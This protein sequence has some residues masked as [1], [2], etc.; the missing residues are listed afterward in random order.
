MASFADRY[1]AVME[2]ARRGVVAANAAVFQLREPLAVIL[3]LTYGVIRAT[4]PL[5]R[6]CLH[7]LTGTDQFSELLRLY[8]RRAADDEAGHEG[9]LLNDVRRLGFVEEQLIGSFPLAAISAM[10]GSQY[11]LIEHYHPAV[12]LGYIGLLEGF[13]P[14]MAEVEGLAA[15][16][17][18][19]PSMLATLK[20][21]AEVDPHHRQE[22]ERVL[23]AVP[24]NS[25][26]R[27]IIANGLR[28]AEYACQAVE[29]AMEGHEKP[30]VNGVGLH[31]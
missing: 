2:T 20:L 21:H 9:L 24:T 3:Q 26:R 15:A 30:A 13:S 27:A 18:V 28:C 8:Y 11:Y 29:E 16:S 1:F 22:L 5:L 31:G 10:V 12:H 6:F 4:T 7:Q 17:G 25:L 14:T 23:N 19:P